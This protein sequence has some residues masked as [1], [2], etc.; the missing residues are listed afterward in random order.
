MCVYADLLEQV[1]GVPPEILTVVTGD[2]QAHD[3]RYADFAAFHRLVKARFE[4]RVFGRG[5]ARRRRIPIRS[6][7][8][9]SVAG[10]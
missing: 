10:G 7:T 3:H 9:A 2:G 4:D 5:R 6:T 8:A 1:Q